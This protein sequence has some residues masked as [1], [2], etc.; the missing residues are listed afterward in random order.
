MKN[1][2]GKIL[3]ENILKQSSSPYINNSIKRI[4]YPL[5]NKDLMCFLDSV[6]YNST[7]L[8][9]FY[10]NLVDMDDNETLIKFFKEKMPEVQIDF[11]NINDYKLIIDLHYN[12]TLSKERKI[13]EKN[14]EPYSN[15]ILILYFDSLSRA[16]ALRQ[17][18]KTTKFFEQFMSY[19]GGFHKKY[20]SENY[21]SFQCF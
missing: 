8:Q 4:G 15:N 18:K 3:K 11:T 9:Y 10:E 5:L 1:K 17:L 13:L 21:H 12:E 16:N 6:E 20:S 2:N 19:K 7:V 14:F